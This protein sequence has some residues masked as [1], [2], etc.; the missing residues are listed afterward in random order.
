MGFGN[1]QEIV[2]VWQSLFRA[3]VWVRRN[4]M[5]QVHQ[6][7]EDQAQAQEG[8]EITGHLVEWSM[9]LK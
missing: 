9:F 4:T 1:T 8:Q 3:F 7:K 5:W 6:A 2:L